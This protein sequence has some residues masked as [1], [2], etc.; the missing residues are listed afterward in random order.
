MKKICL[1]IV[2]LYIGLLNVYSQ[3]T[4]T[5]AYKSRT[6]KLEEVNL[7]SSY[8]SQS[9]NNSAVQGGIGSEKLNDI[10]N[11]LDVK[12]IRYDKRQRKHTLTGE[13]GVDHYT[14]ASSDRIDLKANS[15]A[16]SSDTRV[17]PS[18]SWSMENE[19]KGNTIGLNAS[20]SFEFDYTSVGLGAGFNKKSKDRNR[21]MAIKVQ[22]YIDRVSVISPVELRTGGGRRDE[23]DYPT[24]ARNSFSASLSYSQVINKRLQ[25]SLIADIVKQQGLLSLPFHRVYFDNNALKAELLPSGRLKIP[26]GIRGSYFFGDHLILRA[27]YRYY[28]DDWGLSAN[29]ADLEAAYK[30][31]PFLSVTPFYRFYSQTAIDYFAPYGMHK[32]SDAYY[33]SNYDLSEFSSHFFG[34][35]FRIAPPKGVFGVQHWNM[36]E[37]RFGHYNR[38]TGLQ[39]NIISLHLRYK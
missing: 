12:F 39:S 29:T 8:Y 20:A 36:M 14:S 19:A 3:N 9:G 2:G 18:A 24:A 15:S 23:D 1:S 37:V 21:E 11:V 13:V 34:A 7:V 30:I 16:S 38:S 10:A 27:F 5:T 25:L 35:G 28:R 4:D 26:V 17:Y 6:L 32:A 22:A 31:T 33:S